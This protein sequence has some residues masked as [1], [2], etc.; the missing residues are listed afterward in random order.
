M[1]CKFHIVLHFRTLYEHIR[2]KKVYFKACLKFLCF[3]WF[4][5]WFAHRKLLN[6][7]KQPVYDFKTQTFHLWIIFFSIS[8]LFIYRLN[9]EIAFK[10]IGYV[11]DLL[12]FHLSKSFIIATLFFLR[13]CA[14]SILETLIV[15]SEFRFISI[16]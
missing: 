6:D 10:L 4:C 13:S 5:Q 7:P 2:F 8:P 16:T 15:N 9:S 1:L 11:S 12:F 14:R 3:S